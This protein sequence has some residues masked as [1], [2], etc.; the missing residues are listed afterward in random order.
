MK[1]FS[2]EEVK[3]SKKDVLPRISVLEVP[4]EVVNLYSEICLLCGARKVDVLTYGLML[5]CRRM[6]KKPPRLPN[7][8]R[9]MGTVKARVKLLKKQ[10]GG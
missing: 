3:L 2:E 9:V 7:K 1:M 4:V 5:I 8:A 6:G 10:N